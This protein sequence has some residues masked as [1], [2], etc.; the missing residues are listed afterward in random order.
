MT[1]LV[2]M[3]AVKLENIIQNV[4]KDVTGVSNGRVSDVIH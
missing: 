1:E 4:I 3:M 2:E